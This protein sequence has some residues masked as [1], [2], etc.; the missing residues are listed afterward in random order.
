MDGI[1][2]EDVEVLNLQPYSPRHARDFWTQQQPEVVPFLQA[3]EAR[4]HWA[5]SGAGEAEPKWVELMS[6]LMQGG[7][8]P[9]EG[10][11][12][13]MRILSA[14]PYSESLHALWWLDA[15]NPPLARELMQQT[16][17]HRTASAPANIMWQ[18]LE[19]VARFQ[20]LSGLVSDVVGEARPFAQ[21]VARFPKP[22]GQEGAHTEMPA[23]LG[24]RRLCAI[25]NT[26]TLP[27]LQQERE[28]SSLNEVD[29]LFGNRRFY[30]LSQ[31]T[32]L[33]RSLAPFGVGIDQYGGYVTRG[34]ACDFTHLDHLLPYVARR[35][36]K[37]LFGDL[38]PGSS[39]GSN[40]AR[41]LTRG[42]WSR[43]CRPL[44]A[45]VG[46]RCEM[47]GAKERELDCHERWEYHE[48][49]FEG[50]CG[51]QKLV[52]LWVMCP[53]CHA[54][55]HFGRRHGPGRAAES[56][57]RLRRI[58][59][60]S[61]REAQAYRAFVLDRWERRSRVEWMLDLSSLVTHE[62]LEIRADWLLDANGFLNHERQMPD[63]RTVRARTLLLGVSWR[64][65][66]ESSPVHRARPIEEGYYE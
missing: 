33:C 19:R 60:M 35:S 31:D 24:S 37:P 21:E 2:D 15:Y 62:P 52:G 58:G 41:L 25:L 10:L 57:E 65:S 20:V 39:W 23:L 8:L 1:Y 43:I 17:E 46:Q 9:T 50:K 49:L 18:R 36:I 44:I 3:L 14:L 51:V 48:P 13:L 63:S 66:S 61:E 29:P 38:I 34:P 4:E 54:T 28:I 56:L 30:L 47:C 45:A 7:Q 6:Y 11:V 42:S 64:H 32:E 27:F 40:L 26:E 53:E 16:Y 12:G 55:Q 5:S 59:R 22:P